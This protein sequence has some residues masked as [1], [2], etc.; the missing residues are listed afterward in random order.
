[1]SIRAHRGRR[2]DAAPT[3]EVDAAGRSEVQREVDQPLLAPED[4][5][6]IRAG[7]Y[8]PDLVADALRD[9]RG[10]RVVEDDAFL[11]ID[12]AGRLVHLGDD[13]LDTGYEDPVLQG[14]ALRIEHLALPPE[15]V[16]GLGDVG[17]VLGAGRDDRSA[18]RLTARD[19]ARGTAGE[20]VI[21][22]G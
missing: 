9:H 22:L 19:V 15:Q 4:D 11:A 18:I 21:E 1:M 5:A 17:R 16:D 2:A 20:Q 14:L 6:Q 12:P 13:R 7:R 3:A 8:L 10:L